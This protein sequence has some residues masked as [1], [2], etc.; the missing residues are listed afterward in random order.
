MAIEPQ[1][2]P[3]PDGYQLAGAPAVPVDN[4]LPPIPSGY[5]LQTADQSQ[6]DTPPPGLGRQLGLTARDLVQGGLSLPA[7]LADIPAAAYN[8][9]TPNDWRKF[10]EENQ[11]I[12]NILDSAGFPQPVGTEERMV[13]HIAQGVSG[14]MGGM[15]MGGLFQNA[16]SPVTQA[17]GAT[18]QA[19]PKAQALS[20]GLASGGS[21]L[22]KEAGFGPDTQMAAGFGAGLI[23]AGATLAA[24]GNSLTP[25]A[26]RLAKILEDNG[27]NLT[28]GQATGNKFLGGMEK[29]LNNNPFT[30]NAQAKVGE[31]QQRSFN[32][33]VM[34]KMG[35][36]GADYADPATLAAGKQALGDRFDNL[37]GNSTM[38]V[39]PQ[40]QQ[41]IA[42]QKLEINKR[43]GPDK[44]QTVNSYMDD[45]TGPD[46][47]SVIPGTTYQTMRSDLGRLAN[48]T[49]QTDPVASEWYGK[50]QD[51]VDNAM[52]R[53]L[54]P[55][56]Q[57]EWS[58]L[59]TQYGNFKNIQKAQN[60]TNSNTT[61]GNIN[62]ASLQ[63]A[64][65]TGN[66]NYSTGSGDLNDLGRAGGYFLKDNVSSN[67]AIA[68]QLGLHAM[69]DPIMYEIAGADYHNP[70]TAIAY[71]TAPY[72]FSKSLQRSY[73]AP[74]IQ[75]YL[76]N[77]PNTQAQLLAALLGSQN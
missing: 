18:L 68:K 45:L 38:S 22:A 35:V 48:S 50:L 2:P 71:A 1:L 39:D 46:A 76:K 9:A 72:T 66:A 75:N 43:F 53:G 28:A 65:K 42:D 55:D 16:A 51:S 61:A 3:I 64:V 12:S 10:R 67:G 40:L 47:P 19:S 24:A 34:H 59:R 57:D 49:S 25:E 63:N 20:A 58:T 41:E 7:T 62:P 36:K 5:Q 33:A 26:Q 23:P 17:V 70:L 31:G 6:Q 11:N 73:N 52:F 27:V 15:G 69:A 32:Q 54:S 8:A 60:A 56:Q 77:P 13:N 74:T 37:S 30:A 4:G 29:F 14:A 44:T 21:D